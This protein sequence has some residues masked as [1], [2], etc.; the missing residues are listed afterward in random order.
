M[1]KIIT[2]L[3]LG[4]GFACNLWAQAPK[5]DTTNTNNI[6]RNTLYTSKVGQAQVG[7]YAELDYNQIIDEPEIRN[8]NLDVHRMIIF[9]GHKFNEKVSFFSEVEFEHVKELYVEQAF[10][11]YKISDWMNFRGG[12]LLVPMSI[13]NEYHEP[14]TFNGVERPNLNKYIVPTT[15]RE[16]GAGVSGSLKDISLNYQLYL[17]NGSLGY[18]LD[19]GAKFRGSDGIRK[20]R[21]KGAESTMSANPNLAGKANYY[22]IKG[23]NIGLSGFY[24]K[25]Q[26]D[27]YNGINRNDANALTSADSSVI[28]M[29][30]TGVDFRYRLKDFRLRGEYIYASLSNTYEYNTFGNSDLGSSMLGYYGE[31]AY[32]VFGFMKDWND[33]LF[34]FGRYENYDTHYTTDKS[35]TKNNKYNRN[36]IT[37]GIHYKPSARASFKAD[38]QLF[39]NKSDRTPIKQINLG[40][41]AWF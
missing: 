30:M 3:S 22:A 8:G 20:G 33:Q 4:L 25:T 24:G 16:I 32:N 12:L 15:W 6:F 13:V 35:I 23:L 21:Q 34:V 10:L 1:R 18:S 38:I 40:V 14:P 7:G 27:L 36:D 37:L 19:D 28:G 2:F 11:E 17:M 5:T 29:M 41:G 31:A 26:S 9:L 39:T